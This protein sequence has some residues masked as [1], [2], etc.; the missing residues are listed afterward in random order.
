LIVSDVVMPDMNG[1]DASIAIRSF[2]P[3]CKILLFSGQANTAN[4]LKQSR[5]SSHSF[6][7][8]AKPIPPADLIAKLR[9]YAGLQAAV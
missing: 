5:N 3:Q 1:I 2:L 9:D 8:L 6:E 4:L 7:L